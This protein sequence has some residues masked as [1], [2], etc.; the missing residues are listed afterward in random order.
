MLRSS[1]PRIVLSERCT[2]VIDH[3]SPSG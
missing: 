2:V 1:R 3:S